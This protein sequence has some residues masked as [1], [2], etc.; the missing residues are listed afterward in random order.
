[1]L[2]NRAESLN[3]NILILA[4][5]WLIRKR[6]SERTPTEQLGWYWKVPSR[7]LLH[8]TVS[9]ATD[10]NRRPDKRGMFTKASGYPMRGRPNRI[11]EQLELLAC[12]SCYSIQVISINLVGGI[13]LTYGVNKLFRDSCRWEFTN[14]VTVRM[15]ATVSWYNFTLVVGN[16][17]AQIK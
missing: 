12:L 9:D 16:V 11:G 2:K 13:L 10:A 15:R 8:A 1:M 5:R 7:A 14:V 3:K 6:L 4:Q 17:F